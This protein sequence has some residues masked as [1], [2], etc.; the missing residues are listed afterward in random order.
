MAAAR[1]MPKFASVEELADY[2]DTHDMSDHWEAF[3][4]VQFEINLKTKK[5]L[6]AV[7]EDVMKRLADIAR[8]QQVSAET[9]VNSW[10]REKAAQAV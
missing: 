2:F 5:Y 9:L 8:A 4:E 10:L 1:P 3:P 7:D 6:V